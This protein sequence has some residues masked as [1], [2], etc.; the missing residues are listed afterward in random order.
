MFH[1]H[2][3]WTLKGGQEHLDKAVEALKLPYP[4]PNFQHVHPSL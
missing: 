2:F 4:L 1:G 3:L